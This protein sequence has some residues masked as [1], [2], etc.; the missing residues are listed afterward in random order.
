[1]T[2]FNLLSYVVLPE[3]VKHSTETLT[4]LTDFA[5]QTRLCPTLLHSFLTL[6]P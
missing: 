5:S 6:I 2:T 4:V 1:M 3:T